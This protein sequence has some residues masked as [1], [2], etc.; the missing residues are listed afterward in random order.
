MSTMV[1]INNNNNNILFL[2][3]NYADVRAEK[4]I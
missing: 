4:K 3:K 2:K 1:N